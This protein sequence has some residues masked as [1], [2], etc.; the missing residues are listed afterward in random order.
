MRLKR[1]CVRTGRQL[2]TGLRFRRRRRRQ[3]GKSLLSSTTQNR[4][5]KSKKNIE[6]FI[7]SL[8]I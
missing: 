7:R 3:K 8:K 1:R 6:L 4:T 5:N 2:N